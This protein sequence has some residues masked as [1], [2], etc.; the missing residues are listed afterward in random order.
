MKKDILLLALALV[1]VPSLAT[2]QGKKP[3]RAET[4]RQ[5]EEKEQVKTIFLN[6]FGGLGFSGITFFE[7]QGDRY[8]A[9][10]TTPMRNTAMVEIDPLTGNI[11]TMG[12]V[13][14]QTARSSSGLANSGPAGEAA[15]AGES[16]WPR[17]QWQ[18]EYAVTPQPVPQQ[19][20]TRVMT[21]PWGQTSGWD[22]GTGC[23]AGWRDLN[24]R[25]NG[26]DQGR[27]LEARQQMLRV[28][29]LNASGQTPEC[30]AARQSLDSLVR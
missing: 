3:S 24:N 1:L 14:G 21:Q 4:L 5:L 17:V 12:P 19:P 7:K 30:I 13:T 25:I 27:R 8:R 18:N 2:A 6:Q 20:V 26:L 28:W 11:L 10:I 9:V 22:G 16:P 23:T 15:A 29:D